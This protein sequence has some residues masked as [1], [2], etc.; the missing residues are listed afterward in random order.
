MEPAGFSR[1]ARELCSYGDR[2]ATAEVIAE[3]GVQTLPCGYAAVVRWAPGGRI[4]F[5]AVTASRLL[6]TVHIVP[7]HDDEFEWKC[8]AHLIH[9]LRNLELGPITGAV[10]ANGG[11]LQRIRSIGKWRRRLSRSRRRGK[12]RDKKDGNER[13]ALH[14][15][16]FSVSTR[17]LIVSVTIPARPFGPGVVIAT[18]T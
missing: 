3:R 8:C 4:S 5:E 18:G 6:T 1:L 14:S 10:V 17:T 2:A 11:K 13:P 16:H 9:L 15:A 7:E 12:R